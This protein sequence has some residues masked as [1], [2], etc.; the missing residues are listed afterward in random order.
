[1]LKFKYI[2]SE[3]VSIE[4]LIGFVF[5]SWSCWNRGHYASSGFRS[6]SRHFGDRGAVYLLNYLTLQGFVKRVTRALLCC[7]SRPSSFFKILPISNSRVQIPLL[8]YKHKDWH[9]SLFFYGGPLSFPDMNTF[10][11]WKFRVLSRKVDLFWQKLS[12][13]ACTCIQ[14]LLNHYWLLFVNSR[15]LFTGCAHC[16]P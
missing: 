15:I 13:G 16:K 7:M 14:K 1:M 5:F 2:L 9:D 8:R 4:E 3:P 12:V 10:S 11:N 6:G